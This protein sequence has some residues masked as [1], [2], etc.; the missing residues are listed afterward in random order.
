MSDNIDLTIARA[1][2]TASILEKLNI[3]GAV[4]GNTAGDQAKAV[5]EYSKHFREL[6]KTIS[7]PDKEV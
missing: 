5:E 4:L 3:T 1:Q 7:H 6:Y 2:L